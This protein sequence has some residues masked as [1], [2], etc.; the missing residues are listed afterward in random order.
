M[1]M[2]FSITCGLYVNIIIND[3]VRTALNLNHTTSE[4]SLGSRNSF[5]A[6]GKSSI[7][8][9]VGNQ[10]SVEFNLIYRWHSAISV[11]DENWTEELMKGLL[12]GVDP[13]DATLAQTMVAFQAFLSPQNFPPDKPE[14]WT[15]GG[16]VR[17]D[18]HTFKDEDLMDIL[19]SST[20]DLAGTLQPL[21]PT[22]L[23]SQANFHRTRRI[24]RPKRP[25]R[26]AGYRNAWNR[27]SAKLECCNLK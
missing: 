22:K 27:T 3:Y 4:W 10:V 6:F 9:G 5:A 24:R 15:F 2:D 7:P 16:L 23:G 26:H 18:D 11:R 14:I 13:K 1:L 19:S 8:E 25:H 17:Q 21:E 20:E 12:G